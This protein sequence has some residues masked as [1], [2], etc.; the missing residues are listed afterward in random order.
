MAEVAVDGC[1]ECVADCVLACV[2]LDCIS[3]NEVLLVQRVESLM[4]RKV[5]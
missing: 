1:I 2:K 4:V 5:F 3:T